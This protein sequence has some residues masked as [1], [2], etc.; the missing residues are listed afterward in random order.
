MSDV[1]LLALKREEGPRKYRR[2]WRLQSHRNRILPSS[3]PNVE[4]S[5]MKPLS[6]F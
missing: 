6:D 3:L 5:F 2:L 1:R 4:F